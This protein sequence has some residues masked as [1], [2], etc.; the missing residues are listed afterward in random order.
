MNRSDRCPSRCLPSILYAGSRSPG[1]SADHRF[2]RDRRRGGSGRQWLA[3]STGR[4]H[5]HSIWGAR[6][7]TLQ[8]LI[9]RASEGDRDRDGR[10]R[11][12][13]H[14]EHLFERL[15]ASR[16]RCNEASYAAGLIARA[17]VVDALEA[18]TELVGMARV[19]AC[20][21]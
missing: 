19:F 3:H 7:A 15:D 12:A 13:L 20:A 17:S 11:R 5:R 14:T 2:G 21:D 18:T 10:S 6:V 9:P 1:R 4:R 8:Q 16:E